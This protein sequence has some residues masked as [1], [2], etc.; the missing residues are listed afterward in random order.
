M[1]GMVAGVNKHRN[2]IPAIAALAWVFSASITVAQPVENDRPAKRTAI[3]TEDG[4]ADC[5]RCHSGDKMRAMASSA[6]GDADN[7]HTPAA[8]EGCE[9][10]HGPGSI[11]ISRAHGGRGF[12]PLTQF[13]RGSNAAPRDEQIEVCLS[14]HARP[15]DGMEAIQFIGS[16]HDRRIINCSTCHTVHAQTDPVRDKDQQA[17]TCRRCHRRQMDEHPRFEDKR[18]DFDALSC[19]TCHDVHQATLVAD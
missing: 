9:S 19:W 12:P 8:A 1:L 4:T 11:H 16:P 10:C 2:W 5:L 6:H 17:A 13:G 3:Y 15:G 14:C 18:I 7:P